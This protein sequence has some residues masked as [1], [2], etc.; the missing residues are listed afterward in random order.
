MNRIFALIYISTLISCN[1]KNENEQNQNINQKDTLAKKNKSEI[2]SQKEDDRN[3]FDTLTNIT[4]SLKNEF[5][6]F[7]IKNTKDTIK[8]DLNGDKISDLAFFTNNN[9]KRQIFILDGKSKRKIKF[10]KYT[11]SGEMEDDFSWVDYWGTTKD[12]ETFEILIIDSEIAGD[13]IKKLENNSIFVRKEEV[14]GGVITY[15]NNKYIW[16]HQSD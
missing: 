1:T 9:D 14:G 6:S 3:E 5:K 10:E 15:L 13:T 16:I 8:E 4:S 11:S 2:V 7:E 12:K